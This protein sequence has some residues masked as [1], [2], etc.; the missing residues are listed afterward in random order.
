MVA[1][2]LHRQNIAEGRK[3][4][5]KALCLNCPKSKLSAVALPRALSAGES[6]V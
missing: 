2:I 1:I 3:P 6:R 4:R 5:Y